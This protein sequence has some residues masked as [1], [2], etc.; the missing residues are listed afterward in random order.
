MQIVPSNRRGSRQI[1][2]IGSA[3]DEQELAALKATAADRPTSKL[4]SLRVGGSRRRG[5]SY[6]KV[7]VACTRSPSPK[8]L[9]ASLF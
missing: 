2:H 8:E 1:E 4:D 7:N 6:A 3:D 9:A 5:P